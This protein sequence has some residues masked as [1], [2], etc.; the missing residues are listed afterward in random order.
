MKRG[1]IYFATL[2]PTMGSE[3][4]KTRPVIIISS[5]I[6]NKNSDVITVIPITSSVSRVFPFEVR[7]NVR[8]TKGK[9]QCNQIRAISKQRISSEKLSSLTNSEIKLIEQALKL[10]LSLDK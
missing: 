10:H 3:I 6:N 2:D 8:N 5:D 7:L 9:A 4:K 1:D